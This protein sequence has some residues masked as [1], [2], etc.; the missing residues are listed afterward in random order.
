MSNHRFRA[1]FTVMNLWAQGNWD[2]AIKTYFKLEKFTTPAM[3]DGQLWHEKWKSE[4]RETGCLPKVFGGAK[5][6]NPIVEDKQVVPLSDWLDLV[7]IIDCLDAPTIHEYKTGTTASSVYANSMQMPLYALGAMTLGHYVDKGIIYR[8]NQHKKKK[9]G[10]YDVEV[11]TVWLTDAMVD[12]AQNW[13]LTIASEMHNYFT[14]ND[15]YV[16]FGTVENSIT[17]LINDP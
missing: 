2:R 3:A 10:N 1:S 11:S 15:L 14:T 8:M 17:H 12:K 6:A 16:R 5:L 7:F 13:M 4:T 9:D